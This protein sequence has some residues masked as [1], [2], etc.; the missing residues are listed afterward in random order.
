LENQTEAMRGRAKQYDLDF[1]KEITI[2]TYGMMAHVDEQVGRVL[3]TLK[4]TGQE[5][6]TIVIYIS[7]HGEQLGEHGHMHKA[8]YPYEGHAKVP[9]ICK[10]P[11]SEQKNIVIDQPVSQIELV[12]TILDMVNI[13]Q[14]D[15]KLMND[16]FRKSC[17]KLV[18]PLPGESLK[19][20]LLYGRKPERANA[21]IEFDNETLKDF[22][23]LQYRMLVTEKYQLTYYSPTNELVLFDRQ[24]DPLQLDNLAK[25]PEY[26]DLLN[27][28]L[29]E[30][31]KQISRTEVRLPRRIS[32]S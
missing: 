18:D 16:E 2:Q 12:P 24:N 11:W 25:K 31:L 29:A 28:L 27:E 17:G 14:P 10:V 15:D 3:D 1:L 32:A 4:E 22:D 30:M 7:D 19:P 5:N 23:L 13:P 6:N 8:N 21:L 20:T 26:K 9:F